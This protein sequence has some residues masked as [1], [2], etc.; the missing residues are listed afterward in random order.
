MNIRK[1]LYVSSLAFHPAGCRRHSRRRAAVLLTLSLCVSGAVAAPAQ[2]AALRAQLREIQSRIRAEEAVLRQSEGEAGRLR[3]RLHETDL[4][5]QELARRAETLHAR[6]EKAAQE[7]RELAARRKSLEGRVRKS[8]RTL[9]ASLA[10]AKRLDDGGAARVLLSLDDLQ[11]TGRVAHYLRYVRSALLE[12][13]H[14]AA[15]DVERAAELEAAAEAK[16]E[17]LESQRAALQDTRARLAETY[18]RRRN[19]LTALEKTIA[20]SKEELGG[21]KTR[22]KML[23][24]LLDE[25]ESAVENLP[26]PE[27]VHLAKLR[28]RLPWPAQGRVQNLFGRPRAGLHVRW[29]GAVI[30]APLGS[31]VRAVARGRVVYA[32]WFRGYGLLVIV[33][34]GEG[35]MSLYGYNQAIFKSL[36]EWVEAGERI[37]S[38]GLSGLRNEPGVYFELRHNGVALDPG[39]WCTRRAKHARGSDPFRTRGALPMSRVG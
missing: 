8:R 13:L 25:L 15:T 23:R 3:K 1:L 10:A 9:V 39:R 24:E 36:G 17:E 6:S 38:V 26:T 27:V 2:P 4:K 37:A 16:Q 22:E 31:P 19:Q 29:Q 5:I 34:H 11:A 12:T 28:G 14:R 20:A 21:L 35:Y 18:A 7:A 30:L 32:D 33:D